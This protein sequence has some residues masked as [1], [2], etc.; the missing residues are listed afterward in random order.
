MHNLK[1]SA[2]YPCNKKKDEASVLIF[3]KHFFFDLLGDRFIDLRICLQISSYGIGT[4][5]DLFA[6]IRIPG[7]GFFDD[8]KFDAQ[9]DDFG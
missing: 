6:I 8:A 9:I 3:R 7:T 1:L 4:L 5:T 2:A